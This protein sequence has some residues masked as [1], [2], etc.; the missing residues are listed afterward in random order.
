[1]TRA[2]LW[3]ETVGYARSRRASEA[4]LVHF[5]PSR[6]SISPAI[7]RSVLSEAEDV[8]EILVYAGQFLIDA[9]PD[10]PRLLDEKASTGTSVRLLLGDPASDAVRR[11]GEEEGIGVDLA[12]RIR[13]T[14]A[15]LRGMLSGSQ[16][17]VR[18]HDT[19]L[20]CSTYQAAFCARAG[21]PARQTQVFPQAS[22]RKAHEQAMIALARGRSTSSTQS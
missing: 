19:A 9:H 3:P 16:V 15:G 22:R 10:L 21:D 14:L 6:A 17:D 1:M 5:Y 12:A 2:Y 8:V 7:W 4:E 18:L 13:L 20:Y 11:R